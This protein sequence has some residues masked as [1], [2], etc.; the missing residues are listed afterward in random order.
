MYIVQTQDLHTKIRLHFSLLLWEV[1]G[2]RP[3]W[4]GRGRSRGG[5]GKGRG[6]G[7]EEEKR[8]R[9]RRQGEKGKLI[10]DFIRLLRM[11]MM[12]GGRRGGGKRGGGKRENLFLSDQS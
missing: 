9:G 1:W 7:G 5:R 12:R 8:M 10:G 11:H 6:E 3:S 2:F 4:R